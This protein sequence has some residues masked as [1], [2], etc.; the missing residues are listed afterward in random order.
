MKKFRIIVTEHI[1]HTI[2]LEADNEADALEEAESIWAESG[3]D[4]FDTMDSG[5]EDWHIAELGE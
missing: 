5:Q 1:D 4:A 2:T 3:S